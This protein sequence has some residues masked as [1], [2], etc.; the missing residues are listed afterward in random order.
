[1][2]SSFPTTSSPWIAAMKRAAGSSSAT[3]GL[4]EIF[5]IH[6]SRPCTDW[7]R[8]ASR[9]RSGCAAAIACSSEVSVA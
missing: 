5:I 6:S 2:H 4:S 9:T 3:P 8:L 1:M 7:P